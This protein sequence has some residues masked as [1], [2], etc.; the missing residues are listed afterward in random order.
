MSDEATIN[1]GD[2][3][4]WDAT[5]RGSTVRR[6]GEVVAVVAPGESPNDPKYAGAFEGRR[7]GVITESLRSV[8]SYL[9]AIQGAG[10]GKPVVY[11]PMPHRV[12]KGGEIRALESRPEDE[13]KGKP[14]GEPK[15]GRKAK[16][17]TKAEA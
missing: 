2:T 1:V 17:K 4:A 9:I 7:K 8:P 11:W 6:T 12:T 5:G 10:N 15:P 16:A 3:V 13:T 14:E